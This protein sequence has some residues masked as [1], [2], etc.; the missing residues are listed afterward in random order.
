ME[1]YGG[2]GRW[3]CGVMREIERGDGVGGK[4]ICG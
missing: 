3:G 2:R 1:G 4:E